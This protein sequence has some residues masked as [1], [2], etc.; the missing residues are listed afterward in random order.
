[1]LCWV[2]AEMK[3]FNVYF[4]IVDWI[5]MLYGFACVNMAGF[6]LLLSLSLSHLIRYCSFACNCYNNQQQWV[7]CTLCMCAGCSLFNAHGVHHSTFVFVSFFC[8]R[9]CSTVR[10]SFH[11]CVISSVWCVFMSALLMFSFVIRVQ[12]ALKHTHRELHTFTKT[13]GNVPFRTSYS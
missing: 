1:M 5:K 9:H 2:G 3:A 10:L 13:V 8:R 11:C 7:R 6:L 12:Y 4:A